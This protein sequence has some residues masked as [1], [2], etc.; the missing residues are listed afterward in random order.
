MP[1]PLSF[2]AS[3]VEKALGWMALRQN[4]FPCQLMMLLPR[5]SSSFEGSY[6]FHSLILLATCC[7]ETSHDNGHSK[8]GMGRRWFAHKIVFPG[9][10]TAFAGKR[11]NQLRSNS[12][13][14]RM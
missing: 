5:C 8:T 6:F 7:V 2:R 12:E 11:R 4:S 13:L 9:L 1:H 3:S 14:E 10:A